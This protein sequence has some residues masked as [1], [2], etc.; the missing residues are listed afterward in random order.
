M[1][2]HPDCPLKA[3]FE[4][5]RV[6]RAS[7][8]GDFVSNGETWAQFSATPVDITAST[9][10]A[11]NLPP[12][13]TSPVC[14]PL[15]RKDPNA[16]NGFDDWVAYH[17]LPAPNN[18]P[19]TDS[20]G[21]GISN[22]LEAYFGLDPFAPSTLP[23]LAMQMESIG[24]DVLPVLEF[25]RARYADTL[26]FGIET[27]SNLLNWTGTGALTTLVSPVGTDKENV[28][29]YHPALEARRFYRASS[30]PPASP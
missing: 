16:I 7:D 23:P 3:Q 27:S 6:Y 30:T 10:T 5:P 8:H 26:G 17:Q 20:D 22:G 21:D 19:T 28:W 18:T 15:E 13:A 12:L 25:Q 14:V 11:A 2:F 1:R 4:R 29:I 24:V 9:G